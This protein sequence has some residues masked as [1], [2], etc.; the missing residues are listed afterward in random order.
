MSNEAR[1]LQI[2]GKFSG[3]PEGA[4]PNKQ[5]VTD[6]DGN[7]KWEDRLA[8][9]GVSEAPSDD[10]MLLLVSTMNFVEPLTAN[11][12]SLFTDADGRIFVL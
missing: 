5:L 6:A 3:L 7:V 9:E 12:G 4:G 2:A 11:D 8:Y 10:D 1:K